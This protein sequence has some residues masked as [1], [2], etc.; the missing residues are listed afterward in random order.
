MAGGAAACHVAR[1]QDLSLTGNHNFRGLS[2]ATEGQLVVMQT[3]KEKKDYRVSLVAR[4][5]LQE[6]DMECFESVFVL[7]LEGTS[8]FSPLSIREMGSDPRGCPPG[9]LPPHRAWQLHSDGRSAELWEIPA[10][11]RTALNGHPHP[12][13]S[14]F[15]V[16]ACLLLSQLT[17]SF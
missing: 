13:R 17:H 5:R 9:P 11:V 1:F 14:C 8:C 3:H 10:D 12:P 4:A 7:E 2:G 6:E 16:P 15:C